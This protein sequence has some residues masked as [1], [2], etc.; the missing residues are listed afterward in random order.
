MKA[1][2]KLELE[3]LCGLERDEVEREPA[4][5]ILKRSRGI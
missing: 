2:G 4:A 1:L 3:A 5:E